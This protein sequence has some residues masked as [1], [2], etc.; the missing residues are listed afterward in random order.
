MLQKCSIFKV[1]EVFFKEPSKE[2]Y[3]LEI[4]KKAGI[5]HTS[6]KNY[7]SEL[8]KLTMIKEG[9]EKKGKREFPV[10]KANLTSRYYKDYKTIYGL[11]ELK[12]SGL[13]GF[14]KDRLTPKCMIL[15]G[16]YQKGE[17][18]ESSD[19]DIFA[20]CKEEKLDLSKFEKI[21]GRKI[22]LHFKESFKKYPPELKNNIVNGSVLDGY[23]EA[24]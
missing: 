4:S 9:I 16:S 3:L 11:V 17:D 22:Q 12:E 8:V 15:F 19:I 1:A 14:L 23:L 6:V 20:E 10:Y 24:F 5:A 18:A 7:L 13:I 2:H 21:L